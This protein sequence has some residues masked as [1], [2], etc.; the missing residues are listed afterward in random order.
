MECVV[1]GPQPK[2]VLH[3]VKGKMSHS[4]RDDLMTKLILWMILI[5]AIVVVHMPF[6][7]D[8]FRIECRCHSQRSFIPF[9]LSSCVFCCC[10]FRL[11]FYCAF[12]IQYLSRRH[13][14][15]SS[16]FRLLHTIHWSDNRNSIKCM[17]LGGW[18][19]TMV[20]HHW[21]RHKSTII[22]INVSRQLWM[23]LSVEIAR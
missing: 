5:W 17:A 8:S 21:H 13:F 12:L 23:K 15:Y 2:P 19:M 16:N 14:E 3:W 6:N 22:I 4:Y 7:Y 18:N 11:L 9:V 20:L 10:F 1:Y